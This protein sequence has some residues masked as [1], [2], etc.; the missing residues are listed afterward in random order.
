[1][2]TSELIV[3]LV[4]DVFDDADGARRL[5]EHLIRAGAAGAALALLP[6]LPLHPWVP[7]SRVPRDAD[8]EPP[9]GPRQRALARA[10]REAGLAVHG[11]A[12]VADPATGR[13]FNRALLF[14]ATGAL[15]ASYDKLHLASEEGFWE[16]LGPGGS[17]P[18]PHAPRRR[19][20]GIAPRGFVSSVG[21][22]RDRWGTSGRATITSP[23]SCAGGK[24]RALAYRAAGQCRDE[25][26]IPDLGESSGRP[27]YEPRH[28]D[29]RPVD[30]HRARWRGAARDDGAR[31]DRGPAA[32]GPGR[33]PRR[34]S[35]VS[36][37][38]CGP[39]R[40]SVGRRR[41]GPQDDVRESG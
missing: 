29:G 17:A 14:D 7:G 36:R 34:L 30:R 12:I 26:R 9:G 18:R 5:D 6:E 3:A 11:G 41:G 16:T 21:V 38:A 25:R 39:V 2:T 28:P 24:L 23:V 35:R 10:A 33:G 19:Q 32:L 27:A 4:H 37:R 8:A 1:M 13:R 22:G 31:D 15:L 20:T 40:A